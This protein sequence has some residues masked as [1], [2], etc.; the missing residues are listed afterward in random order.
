MRLGAVDFLER[1]LS[2]HKLRT[3]W[4]H[5]VG[6]AGCRR[7]AWLA[8]I[9]PL[10][11]CCSLSCPQAGA[12]WPSAARCIF[13]WLCAAMARLALCTCHC[14]SLRP[15]LSLSL[16][17]HPSTSPSAD[18]GH[19]ACGQWRCAAP[20]ALLPPAHHRQQR[21]RCAGPTRHVLIPQR[22]PA[23]R[24]LPGHAISTSTVGGCTPAQLQ[25]SQ[26]R[27]RRGGH[28]AQRSCSQ[29]RDRAT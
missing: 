17:P 15:C 14:L 12:A 24:Q 29:C 2:Q 10:R 13:C 28:P 11:A 7:G 3:L 18:S 23:R 6:A 16:R 19:D 21:L 1:P 8:A 4:Q 20:R 22:P 26:R 25:P 9:G 27:E 5:K